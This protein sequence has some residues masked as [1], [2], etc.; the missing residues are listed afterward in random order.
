MFVEAT[1][2]LKPSYIL[3]RTFSRMGQVDAE[4][5]KSILFSSIRADSIDR[6]QPATSEFKVTVLAKILKFTVLLKS[7]V[8]GTACIRM[9]G[10]PGEAW[11]YLK[12]RIR[13]MKN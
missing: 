2:A 8:E 1:F 3:S 4:H 5:F 7:L 9:I 12:C 10:K 13:Q 6:V 11:P